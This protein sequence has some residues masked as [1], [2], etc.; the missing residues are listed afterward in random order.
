MCQVLYIPYRIRYLRV[1][2][3][4]CRIQNCSVMNYNRYRRMVCMREFNRYR[5]CKDPMAFRLFLFPEL[6]PA[7]LRFKGFPGLRRHQNVS[8]GGVVLSPIGDRELSHACTS[9]Y[10]YAR[11]RFVQA[12]EGCY[13]G[14]CPYVRARGR[15]RRTLRRNTHVL[16]AME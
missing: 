8:A 11:C 15:R 1:G 14:V 4:A 6:A 5:K 9:E 3:D 10:T 2:A 16:V 12:H 13:G 7:S